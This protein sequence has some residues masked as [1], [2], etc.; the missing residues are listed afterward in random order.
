VEKNY[1]PI[2]ADF[3]FSRIIQDQLP[4]R[5]R[6][7]QYRMCAYCDGINN[8]N[9]V[10]REVFV[11]VDTIAIRAP[12]AVIVSQKQ[13]KWQ[14]TLRMWKAVTTNRVGKSSNIMCIM[15]NPLN[16]Q[17]ETTLRVCQDLRHELF[18]VS[19]IRSGHIVSGELDKDIRRIHVIERGLA[20]LKETIPYARIVDVPESV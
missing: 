8:N 2:A 16:T 6:I 13:P 3:N 11:V 15:L 20:L 9:F 1:T 5:L 10:W 14:G 18:L 4:S 19:E 17:N 12:R 7:P